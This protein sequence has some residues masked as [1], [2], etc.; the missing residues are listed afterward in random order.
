[1]STSKH[2]DRLCAGGL[3]LALLL[4]L[5]FVNGEALGLASASKA[6][7]YEDRLF[8]TSR[9]HTVDIV[10]DGWEEFLET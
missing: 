5:L 6:M 4:T 1:M 9:V 3:A 7:G 2:I 8:D 10:M